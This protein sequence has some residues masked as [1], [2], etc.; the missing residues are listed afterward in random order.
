MYL[1]TLLS[2]L[3][4]NICSKAKML[5]MVLR[6]IL[7]FICVRQCACR[8]QASQSSDFSAS[9]HFWAFC[10]TFA[11]TPIYGVVSLSLACGHI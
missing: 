11:L 6:R 8:Q 1:R 10:Y 3:Q 7:V 2:R 4:K 9:V 5:L